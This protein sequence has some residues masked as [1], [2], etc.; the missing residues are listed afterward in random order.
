MGR[1]SRRGWVDKD[2]GIKQSG[3]IFDLFDNI[4]KKVYRINDEEFD[5]IC[6]KMSDEEIEIFLKE[7]PTFGERR[8]TIELLN[9]HINYGK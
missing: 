1:I 2:M 8:K 3:G 5:S 4:L 7:N 6:E 9:K